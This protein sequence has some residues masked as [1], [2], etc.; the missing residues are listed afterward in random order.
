M[1][2]INSLGDYDAYQSWKTTGLN[3][4]GKETLEGKEGQLSWN[5]VNI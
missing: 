4:R 3:K 5:Q 1:F 2:L